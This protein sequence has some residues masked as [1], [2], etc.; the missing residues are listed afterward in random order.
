MKDYLEMDIM[1]R[2]DTPNMVKLQEQVDPFFYKER[3][4]MPKVSKISSKCMLFTLLLAVPL[5][6]LIIN[7]NVFFVVAAVAVV[8]FDLFQY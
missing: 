4:T 2:M 1:T 3:L 8:L 5:F 7:S 6:N